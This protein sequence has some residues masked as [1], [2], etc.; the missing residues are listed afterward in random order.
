[1][2]NWEWPVIIG[3]IGVFISILV[4][5]FARLKNA[6]DLGVERGVLLTELRE[7][8]DRIDRM[9]LENQTQHGQLQKNITILER[10]MTKINDRL[11]TVEEQLRK[12][13]P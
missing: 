11:A 8:K 13:R 4:F 1:M 5:F 6:N 9:M 12:G 3:V 7:I 2:E 10:R